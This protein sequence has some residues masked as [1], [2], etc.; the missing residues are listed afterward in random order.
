MGFPKMAR[1]WQHFPRP[2]VKDI[3]AAVREGLSHLGIYSAI[4]PGETVALTVG[5]RGI[6]NLQTMVSTVVAEVK[7]T[8]ADVYIV[9][10]M[11]SHGGAT[12]EGQVEIIKHFGITEEAVGAPIRSSMEV[13][14]MGKTEDGI[15]VYLDRNASEADH[16][17]LL[18]RVKPHTD[19]TGKIESGLMKMM[20][21]GLGKHKGASLYHRAAVQYG[22]ER[23]IRTVSGVVMEKAPVLGGLAIV[24]NGYDETAR[25]VGLTPGEIKEKEE[26]LQQEAKDLLPKLPVEDID[27]LIVDEIGK[28]I[29]G[30]GMDPNVVGRV[31]SEYSEEPETPRIRRIVVLDLTKEAEGNALGIGAADFT[32]ERLAKKIDYHATYTNAFTALLVRKAHL[33]MTFPTDREAVDAALNSLGLISPEEARVVRIKNT[34]ELEVLEVSQTMLDELRGKEHVEIAGEP[35]EMSFLADGSLPKLKVDNRG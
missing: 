14:E 23:V 11:G 12:D 5:S 3:P 19:F 15:P 9:P 29:S 31:M 25:I 20:A 26:E 27:V 17:L 32:V 7:K 1:V 4:K 16:I 10:S 30:V 6:T 21:I 18:N 28:N 22:F 33:P 34:F 24:E 13:V 8:G 2:V 35:V